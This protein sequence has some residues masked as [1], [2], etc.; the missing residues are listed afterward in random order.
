M[1]SDLLAIDNQ[2]AVQNPVVPTLSAFPNPFNHSLEIG[3]QLPKAGAAEVCVYNI[4]G[5]KLQSI[6]QRDFSKGNHKLSLDAGDLSA[7]VYLLRLKTAQGS[8]TRRITL[9][10]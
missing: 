3:F 1:I 6:E 10:K 7:G 9:I 5:Q 2:D 8:I 4:R